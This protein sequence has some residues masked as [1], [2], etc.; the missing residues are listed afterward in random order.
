MSSRPQAL[1]KFIPLPTSGCG[2][3]HPLPLQGLSP[4]FSS[5]HI[6]HSENDGRCRYPN[7][8]R[9]PSSSG[10]WLRLDGQGHL[11]WHVPSADMCLLKRISESIHLSQR[12]GGGRWRIQVRDQV[13]LPIQWE[14]PF[15]GKPTKGRWDCSVGDGDCQEPKDLYLIYTVEGEIWLSQGVL[16]PLHTWVTHI[17]A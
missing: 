3:A 1:P 4:G 9:K 8:P 17:R 13:K 5:S 10:E 6:S 16:W 7:C 15:L 12:S 14:R 2:R 11:Y